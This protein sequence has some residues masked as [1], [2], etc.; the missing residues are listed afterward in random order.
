MT[1]DQDNLELELYGSGGTSSLVIVE[2][3]EVA[4]HKFKEAVEWMEEVLPDPTNWA[5]LETNNEQLDIFI[6][7][8]THANQQLNTVQQYYEYEWNNTEFGINEHQWM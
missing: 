6:E 8:F 5:D 2:H 3:Y 4:V 7:S 1:D